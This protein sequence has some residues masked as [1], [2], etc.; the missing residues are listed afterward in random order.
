[1]YVCEVF[2]TSVTLYEV[3]PVEYVGP[4]DDRNVYPVIADPPFAGAVHVTVST[5][6][7]FDAADGAAGVA[8]AVVG[9]AEFEVVVGPFPLALT[10]VIVNVYAVPPLNPGKVNDVEDVVWVVV[11]G[12]ETIEYEVAALHNVGS[13]AVQVKFTVPLP[14]SPPLTPVAVNPVTGHVGARKLSAAEEVIPIF[15]FAIF[16]SYF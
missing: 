6:A 5:S 4:S 14:K 11:I 10:G 13:E 15:L 1:V 7:E 12:L 3:D 9:V 2:A 16:I 8:G